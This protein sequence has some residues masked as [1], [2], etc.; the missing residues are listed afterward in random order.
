[1]KEKIK[2][3]AII[4]HFNKQEDFDIYRFAHRDISLNRAAR[5]FVRKNKLDTSVKVRQEIFV[6]PNCD[7]DGVYDSPSMKE[8]RR[9]I[10]GL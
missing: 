4:D 2:W 3:L 5:A 6:D 9:R 7:D 1:M 10:L 8:A